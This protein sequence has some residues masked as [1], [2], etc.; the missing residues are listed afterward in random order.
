MTKRSHFQLKSINLPEIGYPEEPRPELSDAVFADRL[1]KVRGRMD[2]LHLDALVVYGDREHYANLQYLTN[3]DPRFEE[4]LLVILPEGRPTLFVGNEGMGY[5]TIARL[6]V[7]RCLYQPFSLLGQPRDKVV[8]LDALLQEAG[9][10]KCNRVGAVGWK[11]FSESEFPNASECLDF[12]DYIAASLRRGAKPGAKIT[13]ECAMFIDPQTGLRNIHEPEQLA[14]FEWI[15]TCNSQAL[16]DGIRSLR[17]G[18][19]EH[20]AFASMRYNGLP[21][22][23][24][25]V[26]SSGDLFIRHGMASP[27]CRRINL[28]DPIFMT[29]SYQGANTCRFGWVGRSPDDLPRDVEDYVEVAASPYASALASW[30]GTL[31]IGATGDELHRSVIECLTSSGFHLGL[32]AGHQIAYDEWTHTLSAEGSSQRVVSGM[33][34]QADFFPTLPTVHHGAFAEDGLAVANS[35][36]RDSLSQRYPAMWKRI[37]ARRRFVVDELGF[38]IS[39][40]LLPFSNIQAAVMPYFL[41]PDLCLAS[42]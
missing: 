27:T 17:P 22:C 33:Y 21:L 20:E 2:E 11:Y 30:Y 36:L 35:E 6:D 12:P 28:G 7:E 25:P 10:G 8:G 9:I 16:L 37:E 41:R 19:T 1:T 4:A 23:C 34:W 40:D 15:S 32:N 29:M 3:Y 5:S 42:I 18:M 38:D 26:C 13:N 39:G 14:D 31:R 24:H